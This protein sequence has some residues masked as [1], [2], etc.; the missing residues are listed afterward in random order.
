MIEIH[1]DGAS[2]GNPGISGAG[3]VIKT[4]N[5]LYEYSFPLG[6]VSN[7]EAEFLALIK[8][9]KICE[10]KFPHALVAVQTDSQIV[11]DS[12]EKKYVKNPLFKPLLEQ[13]N[14]LKHSF[15]LFFIKWIPS[16]QNKHADRL[17]REAIYNQEK[18]N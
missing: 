1:V 6:I 18:T 3:I 12:I 8:A 9:L 5:E 10:Q 15:S 14:E 16:E 2:K 13:I 17:A 11:V 4:D 7:H